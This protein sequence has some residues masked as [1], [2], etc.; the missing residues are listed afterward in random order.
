MDATE[1]MFDDNVPYIDGPISY[2]R[3]KHKREDGTTIILRR[4]AG[5]NKYFI[6][7]RS[8]SNWIGPHDASKIDSDCA[9]GDLIRTSVEVAKYDA[10]SKPDPNYVPWTVL[11]MPVEGV[12]VRVK[13]ESSVFIAR[14]LDEKYVCSPEM[15]T[16]Y[17]RLFECYEQIDGTPCGLRVE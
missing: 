15:D 16:S 5:S 10:L 3:H 17:Q 11:T 9:K 4:H 14:P 8:Q 13:G 1:N 2:Y 6:W 12:R 7:S